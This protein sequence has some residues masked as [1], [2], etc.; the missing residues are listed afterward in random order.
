MPKPQRTHFLIALATLYALAALAAGTAPRASAAISD[1]EELTRF[2]SEGSAAG[3]LNLP[4][5]VATDPT[6]GHV[7]TVDVNNR[8]SEFTPW[9]RFVKAFGWD[10]APGAVNEQQE[11]RVRAA[12]GQFNLSFGG[13]TTPDLPFNA[14]GS[15]SEGPGSVEAALNALSSIS[16]G[17]GSVSVEAV[18]GNSN[19]ETPFV[20]VITFE[21]T[22][23]GTDVAQL[24][25]SEGTETLEGGVPSTALEARTRADGTP[26]GT[27]L[28]SCTA[29]S[30]CKQ[31]LEGDGAGE[32]VSNPPPSVAVDAAGDV[33]VRE[34]GNFRV[35]KFDSAGRFLLMFGGE[36][37]KTTTANRC[38]RAD[39]EGGDIC[40]IGIAGA[41]PSQFAS[42]PNQVITLGSSGQ[43]YVATQERI[44]RFNLEGEFEAAIPVPSMHDIYDTA[45]DPISGDLYAANGERGVR[46]LDSSTGAEIGQVIGQGSVATDFA[47]NVFASES[48]E[49][50]NNASLVLEYGPDGK[51]LSPS[52]CCEAELL[53]G[54]N[55]L[56]ISALATNAVG[57]LYAAYSLSS[58]DSLIRSF[59]PGPTMF[60]A[61]PKVPPSISA[62]FASSV[63]RDGATVA[64]E[65]NPHFFTDTRYYVQY[66]TGKCSEGGCEETQPLAPG[67][68]LAAKPIDRAVKT[69]GI[70]LEGL[71]AGVTYHYRFIAQG[72]GGGPVFGIDP[73]GADG[74]EEAGA[75]VGLEATFNT[76]DP[77]PQHAC[78]NDPFRGGAS[79]RL[80]DCRAY[81]MVSPVDKNNGDIRVLGK[82]TNLEQS[83]E[84][85][86][87][88]TYSS[89]RSFGDPQGAPIANQY[90]A[91]RDPEAG[92]LS[93]AIDPGF[94]PPG[95]VYL[96]ADLVNPY[97]A[98]SSDLCRGWFVAATDPL[99]DPPR[100]F[101][102]YRN[103][104]RR[105]FCGEGADEALVPVKP[106]AEAA[107]F[108]SEPQGAS[109]DGAAAIFQAQ[110]ETGGPWQAFYAKEGKM[111]L[112]C[113]LPNGTP[114]AGNCSGGTSTD[115]PFTDLNL[116]TTA[117]GAISADGGKVY[118]TNSGAAVRGSGKVY[119]RIN[120]G[121]EQG[122]GEE[123]EI[124]KAC[125]V[126]VSETETSK[127]SHFLAADPSGERAL[128][129]VSEGT[130]QGDL[131]KF[132]LGSGSTLIA[133]KVVG[134]VGASEDLSRIYFVSEEALTGPE[135]N[136]NGEVAQAGKPN[137]YLD[138]EGV[139]T[140]IATLSKTDVTGR[141]PINTAR[142]P[143]YHAAR[144]TADGKVLAF[145]S[146]K[147]LTGYDNADLANGQANSEVYRYEAGAAGPACVSCNPSGARPRGRVVR[148]AI[149]SIQFLATAASIPMAT[150][151]LHIPR[152]L[153]ADGE[154]LFF[155]S[156][157]ALLPRD[158]NGKEDV[159]EWEGG[160]SKEACE[161]LGAEL[162]VASSGGCLSL[163]SSGES[164]QDSEFADAN[165]DGR[166]AFFIT[167]ASLLPQDPGLYDV[168]DARVGGGFPQPTRIAPC[169]G[170][171]CQSPPEA[172]NDPTPASASFKGAGN[173][174][175][176]PSK[177]RCAK[178]KARR[179]GRCVAKKQRHP[180]RAS[181]TRRAGR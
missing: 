100:D 57:T 67:T 60:E 172:P 155:N 114:S 96:P 85:G 11:V 26:G 76:P 158:T 152:A 102:G 7:Y 136:A 140:F 5:G 86:S 129:K 148:G 104:Y 160:G 49:N 40:G 50:N 143:V 77:L 63:Q 167:N 132:E 157:D 95:H 53:P 34:P 146:T 180:K 83:A 46:R 73:D 6:T 156:Y 176:A 16:S 175:E 111:H 31:G 64:A 72:S 13:P 123:C 141:I 117:A 173:V 52:S 47:G 147:S 61:P 126:K 4:N 22:L 134:L 128:F 17:G 32:L 10:V 142:E 1:S 66:G 163:I 150:S 122:A 165:A 103:L 84:D 135:A 90:L 59:G 9:G 19:G 18:P 70:S 137:L 24:T 127:A 116:L 94:A 74:P 125:T 87:M 121:A 14:P 21:G 81:E 133:A 130:K 68:I 93:E 69:V 75:G 62:Q 33:F 181:Q 124:E 48:N 51:P 101:A 107:R 29:E 39:L 106:T 138:D 54:N 174:K 12:S 41:G 161:Q 168:Y 35:Q 178:G 55:S 3:Q 79:A 97:K 110:M 118:W 65:I 166:D 154:R 80:P 27:G 170:E 144:V 92:W 169:E 115:Y 171:A 56:R 105:D 120:P 2:G 113:I 149:T 139:D 98:F 109:D 177:A 25:A 99:L 88:L 89:Y 78:P 82:N 38:T 151:L 44:Q 131:Y 20:Y 45:F 91:R 119:L 179:K 42:G 23:A 36:V 8:V 58:V 37:D 145:V 108:E 164:P 15:E 43:L 28:E 159:Y 153:S 162:Y 71:K 112:L 30:G